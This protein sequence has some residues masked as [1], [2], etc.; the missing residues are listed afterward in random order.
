[1]SRGRTRAAPG[2]KVLLILDET[3]NQKLLAARD[4]SGR[5]KTNEVFIRLKDHLNRFP[6]FYNSSIV[7]E[8]AEDI[9][10]I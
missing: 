4:R 6:D 2:N 8:E 9:D 3:T 1:M 5:T 10:D 7:K